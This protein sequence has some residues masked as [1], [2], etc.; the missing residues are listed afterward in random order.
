MHSKHAVS[1]CKEHAFHVHHNGDWSGE[2]RLR[3]VSSHSDL[4]WE[5]R[6]DGSLFLDMCRQVVAEQALYDSEEA[7]ENG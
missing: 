3:S 7:A 4:C 5:V 6:L 2:I 1:P